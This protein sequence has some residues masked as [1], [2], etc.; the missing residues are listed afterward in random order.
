MIRF[1][2]VQTPPEKITFA[3]LTIGLILARWIYRSLLVLVIAFGAAMVSA[4]PAAAQDFDSACLT[5][6]FNTKLPE[7]GP[8]YIAYTSINRKCSTHTGSGSIVSKLNFLDLDWIIGNNSVAGGPIYIAW[9][10][11][12]LGKVINLKLDGVYIAPYTAVLLSTGQSHT[13][14]YTQTDYVSAGPENKTFSFELDP[15]NHHFLGGPTANVF[16]VKV[17]N[18]APTITSTSTVTVAE[19]VFGK[20]LT[21]T[22]T[23]NFDGGDF[24]HGLK[25]SLFSDGIGTN[26]VDNSFFEFSA[27]GGELSFK[28]NPDFENPSDANGD[29]IYE[30]QIKV[31]DG[32]KLFATQTL[33]V[34]I[35]DVVDE[36]QPTVVITGAPPTTS[37]AAPFDI[38]VTFSKPVTGFDAS[39][40]DIEITSATA[41]NVTPSTGL[42]SVYTVTITP[43]N[44]SGHVIIFIH[45]GAAFDASGNPNITSPTVVS[46]RDTGKPAVAILNAP[47]SHDGFTPFSATIEFSEDVLNFVV[48]D[49]TLGNGTASNFVAIDGNTYTLDIT[50][51][52]PSDDL[53]IDVAASVAND[54]AGNTNTAATQV[55]V[56]NSVVEKTL[57]V[58]GTFIDSRLIQ[59]ASNQPD[60]T[61]FIK[62]TNSGSLTVNGDDDNLTLAY[63][64]SITLNAASQNIDESFAAVEAGRTGNIDLWATVSG[65]NANAGTAREKFWIGYFGAHTFLSEDFLV[66]ATMQ[67]DYTE[68]KDPVANSSVDGKGWM[69]GPYLAGKIPGQNVFYEARTSWGKSEN[70]VSPYNTYTDIFETERWM[71]SAKINGVYEIGSVTI[72]PNVALAYFEDR[73]LAYT[74]SL[75]NLIPSQVTT[76]GEARFG[77]KISQVITLEHG[78][79]LTP[80]AALTG[81]YTFGASSSVVGQALIFNN[82]DL[83]A[84]LDFGL[85]FAASSGLS[86]GADL[87]YDGI[88]AKG[89]EAWGGKLG[90]RVPLQ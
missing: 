77:P 68:Q 67:V 3:A 44:S 72:T 69:F 29:R 12:E 86:L 88:G 56:N 54:I 42:A 66:G 23:D 13:I 9:S 28:T 55:I 14:T 64:G 49:V 83:R 84:R 39:L 31:T 90:L 85:L 70:N 79:T 25:A 47:G 78:A 82:G 45:T 60:L 26:G 6:A 11:L 24:V 22:A 33:T 30:V 80:S 7:N 18:S 5:G 74:D 27:T 34:T 48:G 37:A 53:T 16:P 89:Y 17:A 57:K 52:N 8:V 61:G 65:A 43:D 59:M 15:A 21:V 46:L 2:A 75:G 58:I 20:F 40:A 51:T 38:T 36:V 10:D 81:I 35:T 71:L 50:A 76:L 62:G 1:K 19:N 4:V 32:G 73:A 87:F 41:T 63:A